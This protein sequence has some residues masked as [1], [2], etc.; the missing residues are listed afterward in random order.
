MTAPTDQ[1]STPAF[2]PRSA[3]LPPPLA[4]LPPVEPPS[5]GFIVQLF[6]IPAV[7]VAVVI[8]VWLLFG[9]LAGGERDPLDYIRLLRS[10]EANF[11]AALEFAS[12]IRNDSKL[13]TDPKLL[14]ELVDLLGTDLKS[15]TNDQ[16]KQF[17]TAAVGE[18]QTLDART[19]TGAEVDPVAV[20][21]E[22]LAAKQPLEVRKAAAISLAKHE[23]R[24]KGKLEKPEAVRALAEAATDDD[25]QLR[26]VAV[27]AL[28]FDDSA[29]ASRAL[30][31]KLNDPEPFVRYNA[32]LALGRRGDPASLG[33]MREMLT[34][35]DLDKAIKLPD[36]E[37]SNKIEE[38]QLEALHS[39]ETALDAGKADFVAKFRAEV[40][41]LS[42]SG[43]VSVRSRAGALEQR[44]DPKL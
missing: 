20:L 42:K 12:L 38:V 33:L 5:A 3:E 16:L 30:V 31:E 41:S 25:A 43:L 40:T 37:K 36:S 19:A 14:G 8:I 7:V 9:K 27:F 22:A 44:L 29:A 35:A 17:L 34:P 18:F 32:A 26:Q 11:Q 6:L 4:D 28:G 10:P 39:L 1:A 15:D 24:L 21:D 23:A 2:D 13:A